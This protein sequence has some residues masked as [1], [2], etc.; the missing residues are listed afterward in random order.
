MQTNW[1]SS[2]PF[3]VTSPY[4]STALLNLNSQ[5]CCPSDRFDVVKILKSAECLPP[6]S[7]DEDQQRFQ[8]AGCNI[9]Y[10]QE[11][12]ENSVPLDKVAATVASHLSEWERLYELQYSPNGDPSW[13][14]V[15][16]DCFHDRLL[17]EV[18]KIF[19]ARILSNISGVDKRLD[20]L[21]SVFKEAGLTKTRIR[22]TSLA[23]WIELLLQAQQS[24]KKDIGTAKEVAEVVMMALST[25]VTPLGAEV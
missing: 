21:K 8:A 6:N 4:A 1:H 18:R 12:R 11:T 14:H 9:G 25:P 13:D 7:S 3:I 24:N 22:R 10:F 16:Y 23:Q 17:K 20:L 2:K 5:T 15:D 19:I